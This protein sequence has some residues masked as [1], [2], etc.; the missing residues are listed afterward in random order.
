MK[1]L[2][3]PTD[4]PLYFGIRTRMDEETVK[5]LEYCAKAKKTSKS[6]I[7][8][9]GIKAIYFLLT[10]TAEKNE[11]DICRLSFSSECGPCEI[12]V[13]LPKVLKSMLERS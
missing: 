11:S 13:P 5:M 1:K 4:N 2:G 6:E 12:I 9:E 7:I 10:C 3:R 8:R